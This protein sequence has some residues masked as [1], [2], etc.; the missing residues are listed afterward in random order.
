MINSLCILPQ[1][2]KEK[3]V[4]RQT[5]QK[6]PKESRFYGKKKKKSIARNEEGHSMIK[7]FIHQEDEAVWYLC[8]PSTHSLTTCEMKEKA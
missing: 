6:L 8:V 7:V 3:N 5:M 4:K 1:F 2:L